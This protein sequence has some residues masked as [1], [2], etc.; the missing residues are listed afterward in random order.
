MFL[1]FQKK[2]L[3]NQNKHLGKHSLKFCELRSLSPNSNAFELTYGIHEDL[4]FKG[5]QTTP[6]ILNGKTR[7]WFS[8]CFQSTS[9]QTIIPQWIAV[10]HISTCH[11]YSVQESD[12]KTVVMYCQYVSLKQTENLRDV[13]K[14]KINFT[15]DT[16]LI[17]VFIFIFNSILCYHF[18]SHRA[19]SR[20]EHCRGLRSM[21]EDYG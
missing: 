4:N 10:W 18:L 5:M 19:A 6:L 7:D 15:R 20:L 21:R 3:E 11:Y 14:P 13:L 1:L 8:V 2:P 17:A 12:L 16:F 9:K